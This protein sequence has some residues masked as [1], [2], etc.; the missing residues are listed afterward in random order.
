MQEVG[1]LGAFVLGEG[2]QELGFAVELA[3]EEFVGQGGA[4]FGEGD[5]DFAAVAVVG[6]AFDEAGLFEAGEAF[7]GGG[8]GGDGFAGE[9]AGA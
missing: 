8:A 6:G 9:L 3:G 2:G 1:E 4:A 5:L 7:G